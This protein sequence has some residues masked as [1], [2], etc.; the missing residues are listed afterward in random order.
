MYQEEWYKI[1]NNYGK[2]L[3]ENYRKRLVADE[4]NKVYSTNY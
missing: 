3:I 1:P 2:K 4:E